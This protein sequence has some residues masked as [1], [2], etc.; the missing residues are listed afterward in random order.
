MLCR[1]REASCTRPQPRSTIPMRIL[2]TGIAGFLGSHLA[3]TM[4][5]DGHSV[6]GMDS[7]IGGY[8]D[9]VPHSVT[10]WYRGDCNDF[11]T[12]VAFMRVWKPEIVFHCAA[13]AYEGLSVF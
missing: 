7:L 3:D 13:T 5:A 4:I 2:I 8:V 1:R 6:V 12:L 11:D 10:R 9:N